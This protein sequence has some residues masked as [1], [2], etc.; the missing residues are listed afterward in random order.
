[1][2][3]S[4]NIFK[5][6]VHPR[7]QENVRTGKGWS[8][9]FSGK[10][11]SQRRWHLKQRTSHVTKIPP[12]IFEFPETMGR[13]GNGRPSVVFQSSF[14]DDLFNRTDLRCS[15]RVNCRVRMFWL[16]NLISVILQQRT[17]V[18]KEKYN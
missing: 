14:C 10:K 15:L 6:T 8:E 13:L 4:P 2:S 18:R 17:C 7:F 9:T 1:M 3:P 5:F 12:F 16:Y 11:F